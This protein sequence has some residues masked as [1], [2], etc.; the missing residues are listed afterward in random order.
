MN[1]NK[2]YNNLRTKIL[3]E[4]IKNK[5]ENIKLLIWI[6]KPLLIEE[7]NL[8]QVISSSRKKPLIIKKLIII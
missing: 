5:E 1:S 2:Y 6:K 4:G 3:Q 8:T 7:N